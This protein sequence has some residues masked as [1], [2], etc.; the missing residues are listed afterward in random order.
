[1][2]DR[3]SGAMAIF[4]SM[5]LS[6]GV[7][8]DSSAVTFDNVRIV[9][10]PSGVINNTGQTVFTSVMLYP[11]PAHDYLKIFTD[12]GSAIKLFNNLGVQVK[13]VTLVI[14]NSVIIDISNLSG[15]FYF[16][17]ISKDAKTSV[18][19]VIIK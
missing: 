7:G 13:A 15:G 14:G 16:V 18:R 10:V 4:P 1:M 6:F 2:I 9:K 19:K 12:K 8:A 11:N 17:E 5:K 3:L